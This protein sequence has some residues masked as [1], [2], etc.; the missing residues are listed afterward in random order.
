VSHKPGVNDTVPFGDKTALRK[1][2]RARRAAAVLAAPHAAQDAA[3]HLPVELL[4][5]FAVASGYQ[6]LGSE[7]SPLPLMR[8]LAA[9]NIALALPVAYDR[10][11]PLTFH[12]WRD[13]DALV[14]DAFGIPAPSPAAETVH[15][16]LVITPLLAFDRRGGRLGQGAGHY[17]RTIEALRLRGPVFVLGLA[18]A[19][20]EIEHA[21]LEAHDQPLDGVLTEAG[22]IAIE[23]QTA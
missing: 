5:R 19:A 2:M 23:S 18:Y 22:Y 6:A 9:Y 14:N 8:R 7:L 12:R 21:P 4:P 16:D 10:H 17:D 11:S 15:P 20:Q 1:T 3:Q 13:G